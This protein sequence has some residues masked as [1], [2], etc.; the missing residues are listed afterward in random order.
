MYKT[1]EPAHGHAD[2]MT[3]QRSCDGDAS[4]GAFL[5]P[6]L[7][8]AGIAGAQRTGGTAVS[9]S[10]CVRMCM[11]PSFTYRGRHHA[12]VQ[13]KDH[14]HAN[15]EVLRDEQLTHDRF[16][17]ESNRESRRTQQER[18]KVRV[19]S[20]AQCCKLVRWDGCQSRVANFG[21]AETAA[22]RPRKAEAG[23]LSAGGYLCQAC[24][25]CFTLCTELSPAERV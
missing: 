23:W 22:R 4:S 24:S 25:H 8:P 16:I 18:N 17:P 1:V 3:P 15:A 9:V 13:Q 11:H 5:L 7:K 20:N 6:K 14:R 19:D 10:E 2:E 21:H 12:N